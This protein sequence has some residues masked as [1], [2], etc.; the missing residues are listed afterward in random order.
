M[1]KDQ[2]KGAAKEAEG[3]IQKGFGKAVDS[4]KHQV[5]GAI[6]EGA[7]KVQKGLGD[8]K[9]AVRDEQRRTR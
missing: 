2:I 4:P 3:K 8:A 1:N 7:G 6:K 9:E 5:K